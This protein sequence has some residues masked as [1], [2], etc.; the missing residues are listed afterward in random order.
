MNQEFQKTTTK[1]TELEKQHSRCEKWKMK[2]K[3][4]PILQFLMEKIGK[5]T[6]DPLIICTI[7]DKKR[8]GGFAP[9]YGIVLCENMLQD[10]RQFEDTLAHELI[11][12]YDNVTTKIDWKNPLHV[13]CTEIRGRLSLI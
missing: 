10:K 12:A 8:S 13:A 3:T 6:Q 11:H 2:T 5:V 9:K 1:F 4:S 7:C